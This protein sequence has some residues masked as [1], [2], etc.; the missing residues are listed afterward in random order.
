[1]NYARWYP[2]LAEMGNGMVMAMSGLDGA[3]PGHDEQRDVQSRRPDVGRGPRPRVPDLPG[4]V[5]DRERA[6]VLHRV[7]FRLRPGHP[8]LAH[9]R[10]LEHQDERLPPGARHP[11]PAGPGDQRLGAA[12]ARAE[13]DGHGH[14]RRRRRPVNSATARTRADRHRGPRPALD[15]RAGPGPADPLPH[16]RAAARRQRARDR[17]VAGTTAGCTAA[18]TRT[19]GSTT[20]PPTRSPGPPI[21]SPA[22]TTTPAESCCRTGACSPSAETPLYGNKQ[23]TTAG[24]LQPGDRRLLPALHVPGHP[25][26]HRGS[27][28]GHAAGA[29]LHHQGVAAGKASRTCG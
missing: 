29:Q 8:R 17:R 3:G 25:P 13:A 7:Q 1:M 26:A 24:D 28:H 11:G 15:A 20:W 27:A 21:R 10:I 16:H 12:A 5:P 19:P 2:T 9:A 18:T 6:A 14:G 22:A 4:D 23:D